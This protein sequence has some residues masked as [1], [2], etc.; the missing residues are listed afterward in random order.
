MADEPPVDLL[1]AVDLADEL[2][3]LAA[4]VETGT[5]VAL[6]GSWGIGKTTIGRL[7]ECRTKLACVRFDAS[8]GLPDE[9]PMRFVLECA[10][11]LGAKQDPLR[12]RL[13]AERK[14]SRWVLSVRHAGL[15]FIIAGF[16]AVLVGVGLLAAL[17]VSV[18]SSA[19]FSDVV[20]DYVLVIVLAPAVLAGLIGLAAKT[21][22]EELT[23]K[24]EADDFAG[25][26][27]DVLRGQGMDS[28]LSQELADQLVRV[29]MAGDGEEL[30][31]LVERI[32]ADARRA[33]EMDGSTQADAVRTAEQEVLHLLSRRARSR[34]TDE[35]GRAIHVL[36]AA[37]P[38][39]AASLDVSSA[40]RVLARI[41]LYLRHAG[42]L[43]ED[44]QAALHALKRTSESPQPDDLS[45][46]MSMSGA[47]RVNSPPDVG[48]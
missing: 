18:L 35:S 31:G 37:V 11:K 16:L 4:R 19:T 46:A 9:L 27:E 32:R 41:E 47:D 22:S 10:G 21:L 36:L 23:L 42:D 7:L 43:D 48:T 39:C 15:P 1:G 24:P 6:F 25:A 14:L 8:K 45:T 34:G 2:A 28:A 3:D 20:N 40:A 29:S 5:T 30:G 12:Q 38:E 33:A 13:R 17:A 26:Y 44:E